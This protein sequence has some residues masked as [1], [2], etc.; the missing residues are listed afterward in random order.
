MYF[1]SD[2]VSRASGFTSGVKVAQR[3]CSRAP[4]EP[5]DKPGR[6]EH[7]ADAGELHL[8]LARLRSRSL[9]IYTSGGSPTATRSGGVGEDAAGDDI[10]DG[11]SGSWKR[12]GALWENGST[13]SGGREPPVIET[14]THP[15]Q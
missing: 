1:R 6:C 13:R 15:E 5:Q 9:F 14:M 7:K 8:H 11:I 3:W 2:E 10:R 4:A 12:F